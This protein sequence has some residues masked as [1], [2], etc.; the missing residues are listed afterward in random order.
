MRTL[1]VR[2]ETGKT[3]FPHRQNKPGRA[4]TMTLTLAMTM[5]K[6]A[7]MT[8]TM[9]IAIAM[10]RLVLHTDK[11]N[12]VEPLFCQE[13]INDYEKHNDDDN[14]NFARAQS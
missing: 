9:T 12:Q 3:S 11:T 13:Q 2:C 4:M 1:G 8:M 14:D 10:T 7:T 5:K 6:T